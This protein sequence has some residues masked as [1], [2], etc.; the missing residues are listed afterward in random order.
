MSRRRGQQHLKKAR[1]RP[2]RE[3]EGD[4]VAFRELH[5]GDP[6]RCGTMIFE[7]DDGREYVFAD[8]RRNEDFGVAGLIECPT[9]DEIGEYR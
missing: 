2:L 9:C 6:I 3:V 8:Y 1:I 5:P 4:G 7:M